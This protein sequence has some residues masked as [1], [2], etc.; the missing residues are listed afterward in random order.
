MAKQSSSGHPRL[1]FLF[2]ML[3]GFVLAAAGVA[4]GKIYHSDDVVLGFFPPSD[5]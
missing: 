3:V 2:G 4:S 1:A 5:T